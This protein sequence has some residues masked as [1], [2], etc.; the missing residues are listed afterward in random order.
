MIKLLLIMSAIF[1]GWNVLYI[2]WWMIQ[3]WP[4]RYAWYQLS[5]VYGMEG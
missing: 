1:Y 5:K 4:F 3:G 2:L